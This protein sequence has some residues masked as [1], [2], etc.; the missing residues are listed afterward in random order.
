MKRMLAL[1][2]VTLLMRCSAS[3]ALAQR[4]SSPVNVAI[5]GIIVQVPIS[6]ADNI[7]G[8]DVQV[9]A[10]QRGDEDVK[11]E[12]DSGALADVPSGSLAQRQ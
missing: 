1:I 5:D 9:L 10:Q 2:P 3:P 12:A 6:V 11:C 4:Q 7:C 8:V